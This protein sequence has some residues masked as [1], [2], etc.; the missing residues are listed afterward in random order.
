MHFIDELMDY[1]I[2][3]R[4]F[5]LPIE[6]KDKRKGN[7]VILFGT[8]WN[9]LQS[10]LRHPLLKNKYYNSLFIEGSIMYYIN[11][12]D[13]YKTY[14]DVVTESISD[15]TKTP[16]LIITYSG[17][18]NDID[19]I[20]MILTPSLIRSMNADYNIPLPKRITV[21]IYNRAGTP[22]NTKDTINI[23]AKKY[24]NSSLKNY[25]A[26]L[27]YNVME[28]ILLN[29]KRPIDKKLTYATCLYESD[30]YMIHKSD[31]IFDDLYKS[32]CK[33]I[34]IYIDKNSHKNFAKDIVVSSGSVSKL[35]GKTLSDHIGRFAG[36]LS[37]IINCSTVTPENSSGTIY[38]I[39]NILAISEEYGILLPILEDDTYN[40]AY[41]RML[42]KDRFKTNAE[43]K[44]YYKQVK[45]SFPEIKR[46]FMSLD[47][48]MGM[49]LFIDVSKYNAIYL[50]N[51]TFKMD[52]GYK[53]YFE[54]MSRLINDPRLK[55]NG[56]H[57]K[58]VIIPML[59]WD[60]DPNSDMW[61][62]NKTINPISCIYNTLKTNPSKMKSVFG[63]TTFVFLGNKSYFKANFG[64]FKPTSLALFLR[65]VKLLRQ[66]GYVP[67]DDNDIKTD[68]AR[69]IKTNI[70]DKVE[71][72]Q[73]VTIDDISDKSADD[74]SKVEDAKEKDKAELVAK[75]SQVASKNVSEDD[76]IDELDND[77]YLKNILSN[78]S[79]NDDIR[80]NVSAARASRIVK[81]NNELMDKEF[82][83]V[84][85]RDILRQSNNDTAYYHKLPETK[86]E[87][88]SINEE[89]QHLKSINQNK[90]YNIDEAILRIFTSFDK[91]THPLSVLSIDVE[92]TST[93]QDIIET[94]TVKYEAED[95]K[96]FTIKIDVPIMIDDCYMKLRGNKKELPAQLF[97]MPIIKTD[98]DTVQLVTDYNKIFIRRFGT[99]SGKSNKYADKLI[100]ALTKNEFPNVKFT[101]GNNSRVCSKYELPIDYI[102]IGSVFSIIEGKNLII[103]F[104]QEV[105]RDKY[106]DK[107]N[108]TK[109]LP[110]GYDK[111]TKQIMYYEPN[112]ANITFAEWLEMNL[113]GDPAF[114]GLHQ[115]YL[116]ASESVRY[117]YSKASILNVEIPV[118][119]IC[120]YNEG[121]IRTLKKANI[122]Y[123]LEDKKKDIKPS[124]D[125]IKFNDGFLVYDLDYASSLLMNGLKA[126]N[127]EDFSLKDINDRMMYLSFLDLFGGRIK[128]DG[129]DNFY[130]LFI[131]ENTK[132]IL[133]YYKLPTDY[134]EVLLY[135]NRLLVD[136]KYVKHSSITENRRIRRNEQIPAML[137]IVMSKAY[138]DYCTQLKHGRNVPMSVKKSALIDTVMA[139][140]TTSDSSV[141][142]ALREY[143]GYNTVTPKGPSGMNSDRSFTLDKRAFDESMLG[144]MGMSTGF[145]ATVGV[146]RPSTINTNIETEFG[147]INSKLNPE[148]LSI[149]NTFCMTEAIK[150]Y[151]ST[152]DDP[153]RTAMT[154][155]Q[156][157]KHGM[158]CKRAN[159]GLITNGA[160]EALPY[161]ISNQ[162][163]YKAEYDGEVV[164]VDDNKMIV[165][166][167][168]N[169]KEEH[170]FIDLSEKVEKNSSSGFYITLKLDT[171]LKPG[172]K[173]KK[174]DILAYNKDSFSTD[175]GENDN[176]AFNIGTLAK[177]AILF[178]E[179]G[180]ED[181]A[182]ITEKLSEDMAS[183]IVVC[184]D[185]NAISKNTNIYNLV[186]KG[187]QI[188]EG[189]T[190]MILQAA[191][192]DEDANILLKNLADSEEEISNLGRVPIK[193]K[194]TGIVQDIIM[195]RTVD[196]DEL[197]PTLKKI[198]TSYENDINKR[199]KEMKSFGVQH[200]ERDLP[201]TEKLEPIGK[202]KGCEDGVRIEIYLKY[203]D[204][205]SVGDKL[206]YYSAVKGVTRRVIPKGYEPYS[207]YRK[208]EKID[209]MLSIDSPN[210]RMVCSVPN[211]AGIYKVL[212]ELSRKTK[213]M[214][215]IDYSDELFE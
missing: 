45:E 16:D 203:Y 11:G 63:N 18:E 29:N 186:K 188:E 19:E 65:N 79:A 150:P 158:L 162:F 155:I 133:T 195:Y 56:Y 95:G 85:L 187:Q 143:E 121:L 103:Y 205:M 111:S 127:T 64:D 43:V 157:S 48:Y 130:D 194:V 78:L 90:V 6:E 42:Y 201:S 94:Y 93:S 100:K 125:Y 124:E 161:L 142:N 208:N 54:F 190:L 23:S 66:K 110:Y 49:N 35:S 83:G 145:A 71:L 82:K 80:P 113:E 38:T 76:A 213:E 58:T 212:I 40:T 24:Y 153:F 55:K 33:S 169:G 199:K 178:T 4:E 98:E 7:A 204:K 116:K 193:S 101:Y 164:S 182:I 25:L 22:P 131:D 62:I 179:E 109:G 91:K 138:G 160:D 166:Y 167:K 34:E 69:V 126:C 177:V 122:N 10:I 2:Y 20:K 26:Y 118:V 184:K 196:L 115:Y 97:L 119:V 96:R 60:L 120:A 147:F 210:Q 50:K 149:T 168:S 86:I 39:N 137:Y 163:A 139:N 28:M 189:D 173:F 171:D 9:S 88:S 3:N 21:N 175:I 211:V 31:W 1:K 47:K 156:T 57:T 191:Y 99:T 105:M 77:A 13:D 140:C 154:Y 114:E 44:E 104:N 214:A 75:V 36:E 107:I 68:S 128:S 206:I 12:P 92:D 89:W 148:D 197:S 146:S 159:P 123:R 192:D 17:F 198:F 132:N 165:K 27:K 30:L 81:L 170:Q 183:E 46:T 207:E 209:T 52:K 74:V 72:T 200:P 136:N 180:Y 135:A 215:G 185:I 5:L 61:L 106:N 53:T 102:D 70:I 14:S 51:S 37:S 152:R 151:G 144:I 202:L 67:S 129:L 15:I 181:S 174:G 134:I 117:T 108:L 59:D 172:K 87:V 73:G 112:E 176:P 41:K 8:G 84:P 141:I 32:L